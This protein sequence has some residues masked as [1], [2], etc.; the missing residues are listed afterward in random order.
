MGWSGLAGRCVAGPAGRSLACGADT[1]PQ[2]ETPHIIILTDH[3]LPRLLLYH[4]PPSL[5]PQLVLAAVHP[6]PPPPTRPAEFLTTLVADRAAGVVVGSMWS[7][8]VVVAEVGER[9]G[10]GGAGGRGKAAP[11]ARGGG[12]G[13]IGEEGG[14]GYGFLQV[15]DIPYV[16]SPSPPVG[17]T[18]A[19]D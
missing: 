1:P 8:V 14:E 4:L 3:P 2:G 11:G 5:P 7:G 17:Y 9:G 19:R 6:L 18:G 10:K 16:S 12:L 13:R 15:F